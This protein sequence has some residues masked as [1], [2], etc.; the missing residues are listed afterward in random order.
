MGRM[1]GNICGHLHYRN[2]LLPDGQ[3]D[4]RYL[5]M[6]VE[7]PHVNYTPVDFEW[8]REYFKQI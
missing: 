3:I 1:L 6:A 8:V 4:K 7:Q 2:V 5:V